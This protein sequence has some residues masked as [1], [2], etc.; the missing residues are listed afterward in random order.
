MEMKDIKNQYPVYLPDQFLTSDNLNE[1]FSFLECH[2]RVTRSMIIGQG[3]IDGL[4]YSYTAA[5]GKI[6]T[7]DIKPGYGS[8]KDGYFICLPGALPADKTVNFRYIM[9]WAMPAKVLDPQATEDKTIACLRLLSDADLKTAEIKDAS[10]LIDITEQDLLSKYKLLLFADIKVTR[11][12]NCSPGTC[13]TRGEEDCINT[14]AVLANSPQFARINQ[15][16]N[17]IGSM[18]LGG[19]SG[20]SQLSG[21]AEFVTRVTTLAKNNLAQAA[22]KMTEITVTAATLLPDEVTVLKKGIARLK[23]IISNLDAQPVY[24]EH[25]LLFANDLQLSMNEFITQYNNFIYKYYNTE[26]GPRFNRM[27]VLGQFPETPTDAFRYLW[28]S[29]LSSRDRRAGFLIMANLC[30]RISVLVNHFTETAKLVD[31]FVKQ[32]GTSAAARLKLI[33]DKGYAFRLGDRSVPCY[34]EVLNG[35]SEIF[36]SY[37]RVQDLDTLADQAFNYFDSHQASRERFSN[38]FRFNLTEYPFYRVEGHIGLKPAEALQALKSMIANLDIPLQA[39]LVEVENQQWSGFRDKYFEF[40]GKYEAFY[41]DL[42]A[43]RFPEDQAQQTQLEGFMRKFKD[44]RTT[45]N[46]T[47]YRDIGSLK[48]IM[49]DINAYGRMFADAAKLRTA[50][51]KSDTAPNSTSPAA[52]LSKVEYTGA[53]AA[54][55]KTSLASNNIFSLRDDLLKLLPVVTTDPGYSMRELRGLEYLGGAYKGGTIVLVSDGTLVIG[56]FSLP[57]CVEKM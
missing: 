45:I 6:K 23:V 2:E 37:W 7:V 17:N 53:A 48:S 49:N 8:S 22:E 16:Y 33:P 56:D 18:M 46:E 36:N 4:D 26:G 11:L 35:G 19:L 52:A 9:N 50:K 55:I 5:G 20:I 28:T 30:R 12:G 29:P 51:K 25:Y 43:T 10:R 44:M 14:I 41:K 38:P 15:Y 57:F 31:V 3:I 13:N 21:K 40:I 34:Y 24:R 42:I 27:L 1:S 47:S 54:K 32:N 39:I